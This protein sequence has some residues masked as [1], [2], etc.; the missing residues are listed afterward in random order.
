MYCIIDE[1]TTFL[2][3]VSYTSN[4]SY[5]SYTSENLPQTC[6]WLHT[7]LILFLI[8]YMHGSAAGAIG[9]I[10]IERQLLDLHV[11]T[12]GELAQSAGRVNHIMFTLNSYS[13]YLHINFPLARCPTCQ[14]PLLFH[15]TAGEM[16]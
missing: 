1:N 15:R 4:I 2:L 3:Q 9:H 6:F 16:Q 12:P 13:M 10:H 5:N 8:Y 11:T 7:F 14:V